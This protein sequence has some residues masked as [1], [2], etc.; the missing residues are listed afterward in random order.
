MDLPKTDSTPK[1]SR[2]GGFFLFHM[3]SQFQQCFRY[4]L[5]TDHTYYDLAW[6]SLSAENQCF[7]NNADAS[8][9]YSQVP[10][11]AGLF[12]LQKCFNKKDLIKVVKNTLGSSSE[13]HERNLG[14]ILMSKILSFKTLVAHHDRY[15]STSLSHFFQQP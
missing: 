8:S 1:L 7:L 15:T 5:T 2:K 6:N 13:I 4:M 10:T 12:M 9:K 3:I 14:R 11:I